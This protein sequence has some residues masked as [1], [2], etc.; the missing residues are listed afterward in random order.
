MI[1]TNGAHFRDEHGRTLLLRGANLSG[2]SKVPTSPDGATHR[3]EGFYAHREV[4][5]VGRPFSLQTADE[6]LRRLASWG[7]TFLRFLIT[8]E[9]VEH[10]GPGQYDEEYLDYI[11]AVLEKAGEY[12]MRVFIDVHQDVWSRWTGGDGAPGW[13]LEAVGMDVTKLAAT[14]AAISHATHGDHFP[15]MIWPTNYNRFGAAT[16]FTLFFAGADF[17]PERMI[18]GVN[19]Q[20]YLQDHYVRAMQHVAA[21]L[22]DL[23]HVIG[24]DAMNEPSAGWIGTPNLGEHPPSP[25]IMIGAIPTPLQAL[26][27][28]SGLPQE[29]LVYDIGMGFPSEQ[30]KTIFNP[31]GVSLWRPGYSCPWA[32]HGV[33]AAEDGRPRLLRPDYFAQVSGKPVDFIHDYL[34]PFLRRFIAAVREV[35]PEAVF[36]VEGIPGGTHPDWSA[37][38]APNAVNAAHWYDAL[39]LFTKIYNDSLT[40]DFFGLQLVNGE[41]AVRQSYR[42]QLAHTKREARDKM[43][44]I[45]T[46]IGEFG[47]PFDLFDK[48]AYTDG[49]FSP[50]IR[51]LN[52]YYDALDAN[53]LSATIWNYSADNTNERGDL[54]NDEDLSIF[55]R[56]Q[57]SQPDD[58]DSGGRALAGIV[59]PYAMATAGTPEH[60]SFEL[61]TRTFE[62]VY[63]VDPDVK[64]PTEVYIPRLQYPAGIQVECEGAEFDDAPHEQRLR[65]RALPGAGQV[66]IRVY[67]ASVS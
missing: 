7:M 27:A 30:S 15:R 22:R 25:M 47:L 54:W 16:L 26:A 13:T 5:F 65:V 40:F 6:H 18:D 8:W 4:S 24:W 12:G 19:V 64:A 3:L 50:H 63:T 20:T 49:D 28:A 48:S 32:Q 41:E 37:H 51:A 10:A 58:L 57:Q 29:V 36:F 9:A 2:S 23:P 43:G 67:P 14:G 62:Y 35:Q 60:M 53:L 42:D 55:S 17:A 34:K 59:R 46:L 31:D 33:W 61:A 52:N 45:P 11:H 21:R 1:K 66:V 44:D 56:D 39:T 38:D